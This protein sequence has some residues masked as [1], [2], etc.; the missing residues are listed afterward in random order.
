[1]SGQGQLYEKLLGFAMQLDHEFS[2]STENEPFKRDFIKILDE[3]RADYPD[4]MKYMKQISGYG[5]EL[6]VNA[7]L[8][9]LDCWYQKWFGKP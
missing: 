2:L 4:R 9:A 8:Y 6:N 3:A 7:F 5:Q 1:M